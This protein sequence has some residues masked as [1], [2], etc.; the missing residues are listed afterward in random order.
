MNPMNSFFVTGTDTGVG[1]TLVAGGIAAA[2]KARGVDV[3]VMKPVESGCRE[4]GGRLL[5]QDAV[6]LKEMAGCA[7]EM[8]LI[9]PYS[10]KEA[11]TPALAA[12]REGVEIDLERIRSAYAALAARHRVMIV[13]GA[14]GILSPLW[15]DLTTADLAKML[16]LPLLIVARASLGTINHT[17]LALYYARTEA[18]P[19]LGVVVNHTAPAAGLAGSLGPE[20]LRRWGKAPLLGVVPYLESPSPESITGAVENSIDIGTLLHSILMKT[21]NHE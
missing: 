8:S 21:R 2:M 11:L 5:A 9:N 13:E 16:G 19:V 15:K 14:G 7:D 6:F 12:E 18:I 17:L 3:G 20:S 4:N 10:L 1:K